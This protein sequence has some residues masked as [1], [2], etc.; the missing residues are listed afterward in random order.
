MGICIWRSLNI[1]MTRVLWYTVDVTSLRMHHWSGEQLYE[2][3]KY[4]SAKNL[5]LRVEILLIDSL[6]LTSKQTFPLTEITKIQFRKCGTKSKRMEHERII[7]FLEKSCDRPKLNLIPYVIL[8]LITIDVYH[9]IDILTSNREYWLR[10]TYF[11]WPNANA[12]NA[13]GNLWKILHIK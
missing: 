9:T 2:K 12:L 5:S 4:F 3:K 7:M 6:D 1:R 11:F 8:V 13:Y 10:K